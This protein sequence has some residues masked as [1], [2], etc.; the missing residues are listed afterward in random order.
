MGTSP[1]ISPSFRNS[2]FRSASGRAPK[3][4]ITSAAAMQP[5]PQNGQRLPR[6]QTIQ[7]PRRELIPRPGRIDR[8]H[9]VN[10]DHGL[11]FA[12]QDDHIAARPGAD[13]QPRILRGLLQ[14]RRQV[15]L[16]QRRPFMFIPDHIVEAFHQPPEIIPVPVKTQ[17]G[18]DSAIPALPPAAWHSS[19]AR[20]KACFPLGLS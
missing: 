9:P 3:W 20:S 6:R 19:T 7:E 17:N 8:H 18:S 10:R 15:G 11:F 4:L 14:R 2:P 1:Q 13:H 12:P 5:M 16:I